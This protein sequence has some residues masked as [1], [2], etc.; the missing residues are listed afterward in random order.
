MDKMSAVC[1]YKNG[2]DTNHTRHIYRR[3]HFVRN[4][5]KW[6]MHK[7]DWCE[8]SMQL[9]YIANNNVGENDLNRRIKYMMAMIDNWE[10]TLDKRGDRIN[11]SIW[12]KSSVWLDYIE[13][14]IW[15]NTFEM[16]VSSLIHEKNIENC[17]F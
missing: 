1:M 16:F 9:A 8:G 17:L 12:K 6:K 10:R 2:K 5:E 7:I 3:I 11:Y 13:V 15:I 14:R 4:G